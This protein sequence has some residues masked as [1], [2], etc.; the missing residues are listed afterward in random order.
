[1]GLSLGAGMFLKSLLVSCAVKNTMIGM[2]KVL[3]EQ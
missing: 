2:R 1:M 3:C